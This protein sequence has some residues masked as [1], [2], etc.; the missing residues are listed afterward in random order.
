MIS[1]SIRTSAAVEP[2]APTMIP[3]VMSVRIRSILPVSRT[4][5]AVVRETAQGCEDTTGAETRS[6]GNAGRHGRSA[7]ECGG[8]GGPRPAAVGRDG[9][10]GRAPSL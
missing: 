9:A 5:G 4:D 2:S 8:D 3:L 6:G 7:D 1:S 10:A